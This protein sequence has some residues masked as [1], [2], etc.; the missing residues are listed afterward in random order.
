MKGKEILQRHIGH[1]LTGGLVQSFYLGQ[2]LSDLINVTFLKFDSE[3][4]H[5][6]IAEGKTTIRTQDK[7]IES[8]EFLGDE[9]FKYP[10]RKIENDFP[11]FKK[12]LNKRLSGFKELVLKDDE[13]IS[14]GLHLYFEDDLNFMVKN[15]GHTEDKNEYLFNI[16][17]FNKLKEKE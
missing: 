15:N 17:E 16:V 14:F 4:T 12:Y 13:T 3:W 1:R 6:V 10:I 11:E 8:T 2:Q 9:E 7:A 5:I